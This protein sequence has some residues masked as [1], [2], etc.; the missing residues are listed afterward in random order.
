MKIVGT[1]GTDQRHLEIFTGLV[2]GPPGPFPLPLVGKS[3]YAF[4]KTLRALLRY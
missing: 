2:R 4:I 3:H 1:Q